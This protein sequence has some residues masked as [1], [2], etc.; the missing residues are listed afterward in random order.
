MR[1]TLRLTL[2]LACATTLVSAQVGAGAGFRFG[3]AANDLFKPS[4]YI[5]SEPFEAKTH[6]HIFG[7][8]VELR[9]PRGFGASVDFLHKRYDETGGAVSGG[10]YNTTESSWEFPIL[11]KYRFGSG[12][13]R[14]YVEAGP[15]FNRL[16]GYLITYKTLP[17]APSEQPKVSVL[18]KGFAAG[19]GLEVKLGPLRLQ[20]AVRISHWR[21]QDTYSVPASTTAD[22][23]FGIVF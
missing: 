14:P 9:L 20:P 13:L 22:V 7:P 10:A 3:A 17:S 16:G 12:R 8:T 19:A 21:Q 1:F 15:S 11:A 4:G 5:G 23:L 18:R 2:L 6:H